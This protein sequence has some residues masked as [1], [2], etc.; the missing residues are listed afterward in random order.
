MTGLDDHLATGIT[1]ICR[2]WMIAR[3]DGQVMGFT[4]HDLPLEF[5]GVTFRADAGLTAR[6]LEQSTG[7]S[8]DNS[9]AVGILRDT[10]L[11]EADIA[12]GRYDGATVTAWLVNWVDPAQRRVR[13]RGTI[14]EIKSGD[15]A[16]RADL[17]GLTEVLNQPQGRSYNRQC[18]AVLGDARCRFDLSDEGYSAN[19]LIEQVSDGRVF[20][21]SALTAFEP[22]WFERG[23]LTVISGAAKA[24][25]GVIKSDAFV[26]GGM[27]EL[28]LWQTLG[29]LPT[30][31]DMVRIEA[32]C[33]KRPST[34]R[35]KFANLNNFR[36]FPDVPGEEWL[37]SIPTSSSTNDGG[38]RR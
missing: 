13:F 6:A 3:T 31:G 38:S 28:E 12:A 9:E 33:D 25:T 35:L 22:R 19:L 30:V 16:F 5:D 23:R 15:G 2:A 21:F 27:R 24:L 26:D 10:S 37:V 18:S 34:C 20:S 36:G 17:R 29:L 14:G 11:T 32:G 8:V 7:L 4:D 1:T